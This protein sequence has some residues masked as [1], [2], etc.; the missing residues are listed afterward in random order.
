MMELDLNTS[1]NSITQSIKRENVNDSTTRPRVGSG[2]R[3]TA[4]GYVGKERKENTSVGTIANVS[5]GSMLMTP[6]ETLR[7]SRP[8]PKGR[9][10]PAT[11]RKGVAAGAKPIRV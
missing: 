3:R 7:L 5:Q 10:T 4:L 6:G 11:A 9:P 8:R 1:D 2:A